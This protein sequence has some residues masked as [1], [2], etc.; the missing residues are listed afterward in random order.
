[1]PTTLSLLA[2]NLA[3]QA[4]YM[5]QDWCC[6]YCTL[7]RTDL[8]IPHWVLVYHFPS[9]PL[10]LSDRAQM[11]KKCAWGTSLNLVVCHVRPALNIAYSS[12]WRLITVGC[13][14]HYCPRADVLALLIY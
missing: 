9:V 10:M 14:P 11:I 1:M 5:V 4:T 3:W 7:G 6:L 12:S 2:V 13:F 8:P